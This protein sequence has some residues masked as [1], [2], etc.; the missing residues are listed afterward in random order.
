MSDLVNS[1][2]EVLGVIFVLPS[3]FLLYRQKSVRGI[4]PWHVGFFVCWGYWNI[5][6][7]PSLGQWLSAVAAGGLAVINSAYLGMMGYYLVKE[8]SRA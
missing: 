2:F 8:R 1:L 6:Y 5:Y 7:Y 3:I 4:S